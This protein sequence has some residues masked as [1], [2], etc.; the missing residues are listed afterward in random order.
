MPETKP[1]VSIMNQQ[2]DALLYNEHNLIA[3]LSNACALLNQSLT[4]L[5]W[6]GFYLYQPETDDLILGPFQGNVACV[7]IQ[8]GAGVC[9]TALKTQS[10]Q[11]VKN[12]H[13]FPGHIA[14]DSASNSEIVVPLTKDG[15]KIGV[16]DIDSPTLARFT[17]A[18]Q[19]ELETF[20]QILLKHI[21]IH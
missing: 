10:T 1:T 18:D 20:A 19:V 13:E 11:L 6:A 9:G 17:P 4:D 2:L 5:N 16:M 3:N 8:N 7:H 15:V 12:V 14:C 21:D